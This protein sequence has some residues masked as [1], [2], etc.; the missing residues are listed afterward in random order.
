MTTWRRAVSKHAA[1]KSARVWFCALLFS[2][3]GHGVAL[4][5]LVQRLAE[6]PEPLL[7]VAFVEAETAW[8]E[9]PETNA[10]ERSRSPE[11]PV[12]A[13]KDKPERRRDDPEE[14]AERRKELPPEKK[15]PENKPIDLTMIPHLK[16]VDQDQFP[17]E[18]DNADA[19]FLAQKNH[20][21]G[22]DTQA[23]VRNLIQRMTG[24]QE[25]STPS[26]NRSEQIGEAQ[27]KAAEL[28]D[29]PGDKTKLP[30]LAPPPT[31]VAQN[32][33]LAVATDAQPNSLQKTKAAESVGADHKPGGDPMEGDGS[34]RLAPGGGKETHESEG[35]GDVARGLAGAPGLSPSRLRHH[36][37]DRIVGYDV[38]ES[39][40][41]AA[42]RAERSSGMGRWDRI[43]AKQALFRASLENFTPNVRVGNQSELGTRAHPFAAY[44][45]QVHR[46]IHRFWGD[47]FLA[48][49]DRKTGADMY[50]RSL[51]AV[52]E[53]A[54]KPDGTLAQVVIAKTSGVL[55]FDAAAIDAVGSAAPFGEP[56][57]AIK[58]RDGN[59]YVTWHFHR[60]ERQCATDFVN[61]HILTTPPKTAPMVADAAGKAAVAKQ[62][63]VRKEGLFGGFGPTRAE[64]AEWTKPSAGAVGKNGS[65]GEPPV[66]KKGTGGVQVNEDA[67][68]AAERWVDAYEHHDIR[69]LSAGSALP[70]TSGG[71]TVANDGPALRAF[72]DEMLSEGTPKR[73]KV[74]FYTL[75]EVKSR[76]GREPRGAE[77]DD[78]AFAWVEQSG[79]DLILL[80][81]PTEKGWKVV[82]LDR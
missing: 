72:F 32:P 11:V 27:Q 75:S 50:A 37:Y 40:R 48:D 70:F 29:R 54:I 47:G 23:N 71:R 31:R 67:K 21:V 26:E 5:P 18:Q 45:A 4:P 14:I 73:E 49:L 66:Q 20:R 7:E 16:M 9:A 60:D 62:S 15:P 34:L 52:L 82:G 3:V 25:A 6:R 55:P 39:E 57:T 1:R 53:I 65:V 78:V 17:D 51:V 74:S 68:M 58:S 28:Q 80:L 13:E 8:L 61:A 59:V 79:E 2:A 42:A 77:G 35:Q 76:L 19:R 38:A 41:R 56:P 36:D 30:Q 46:Q 63:P 22:V 81:E 12:R 64:K 10:E 24:E 33:N 43:V 69:R 44:I